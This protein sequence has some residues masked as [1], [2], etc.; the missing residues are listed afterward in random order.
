LLTPCF[1]ILGNGGWKMFTKNGLDALFH[2]LERDWEESTEFE[3]LSRDAHLAIALSDAGR[4][5][6]DSIDQ[7]VISLVEKYKAMS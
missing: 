1:V 5:L 7:R 6:G 2:E 3:Q 4:P